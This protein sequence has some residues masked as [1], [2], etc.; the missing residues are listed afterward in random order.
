MQGKFHER[1]KKTAA[2]PEAAHGIRKKER[3]FYTYKEVLFTF[4]LRKT[5]GSATKNIRFRNAKR[6]VRTAKT[7]VLPKE[8]IKTMETLRDFLPEVF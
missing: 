3:I 2:K 6:T 8:N 1:L 4:P 5:Y 7:Y